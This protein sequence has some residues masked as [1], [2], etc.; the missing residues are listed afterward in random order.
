MAEPLGG[1]EPPHALDGL[2]RPPRDRA[3]TGAMGRVLVA[4][5][6]R[7]TEPF[8]GWDDR[9][10]LGGLLNPAAHD[11]PPTTRPTTTASGTTSDT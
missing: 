10:Y 7:T 9:V 5:P 3:I 2:Q 1:V 4:L 11:R 6:Q 8:R